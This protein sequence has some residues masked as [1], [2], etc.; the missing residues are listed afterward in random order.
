MVAIYLA[1]M[2]H[3][4]STPPHHTR[5]STERISFV[6]FILGGGVLFFFN[7]RRVL[8]WIQ[9]QQRNRIDTPDVTE[10]LYYTILDSKDAR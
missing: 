3:Q 4:T 10:A 9:V 1:G 6:I 2:D 7:R 5:H 8:G